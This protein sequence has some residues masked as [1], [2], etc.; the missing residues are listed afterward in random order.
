MKTL[1][2]RKVMPLVLTMALV[3]LM[4]P[5][6]AL[7]EDAYTYI[8]AD[9]TEKSTSGPVTIIAGTGAGE[10]LAS[11][12]YIVLA[13]GVTRSSTLTVNG[14]VHLI[15][16]D[17]ASLTVTGSSDSAGVK[18]IE[19]KSLTIYGQAG[20]TGMLTANGGELGAGI[21]SSSGYASGTVNIHGGTVHATGGGGIGGAG[22]GGAGIGGGYF[23]SGTVNISGGTVHA[24]GGSGISGAGGAGIGGGYFSSGTVNISGGTVHA[25]GGSGI[26]GAGGAGIGGGYF[27]SGTVNISGGTVHATGGSGISG[28]G[29][30]GIGGGYFSSG[31]VNISGGSV[32]AAGNG[33]GKDIG[34]GADS[35][36]HGTLKNGEGGANVYLTTVTLEG[37]NAV[38]P[39][40]SITTGAYAYGIRDM[41]TDADGKLYLYLPEGTETTAAQTETGDPPVTAAYTASGGPIITLNDHS[42]KGTLYTGAPPTA[43]AF[44]SATADGATGAVTSTRIDLAFS[45]AIAGLTANDITITDGT[46]SAIKGALTGSGTAWSIALS[47]VATEGTISVAV[48]APAGYTI[49]GS[50]RTATV[51][52]AASAPTAIAFTSATT[53]GAAGT[54]TS[55]RIDLAFSPAIAGLTANDITIT[56]GTG[57]AIK[58]ALTGSGTAWSIALSSVATEGTISVAVSAPAGYTITGSPQTATVYKAAVIDTHDL[59]VTA[60]DPPAGV[61]WTGNALTFTKSG[62]YTVEMHEGIELTTTDRIVVNAPGTVNLTLN[63][64]KIDL[65][66]IGGACVLDIQGSSAV[67]LT[68]IGANTLTSGINQAGIHVPAGATLTISG[69]GSLTANGGGG[70]GPGGA[71][72]GGSVGEAGG[73]VNISGGTGSAIKGALTGSGTAWSIALSSVATEGTISVAV[74]APAGYTITG[75]PRTATVYK[76]V[77]AV[78]PSI[79]TTALADATVGLAYTQSIECSYTGIGTLTFSATGLPSGLSIDTGTGVISGTPAAGTDAGFPYTVTVGVTDGTLSDSGTYSLTVNAA[80]VP[81]IHTITASAGSGGRISPS[82]A[83]SVTEGGSQTFTITANAGYAISS[84]MVDGV[85]VGAVSSHAFYSVAADHTIHATFRYMGPE[86]LSRALIDPATGIIVSGTIHED[87]QLTVKPLALHLEGACATCDAIRKAQKDKRMIFGGHRPEPGIYRSWPSPFR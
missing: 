66:G 65:A 8:D 4:L 9:G 14:S 49:T 80:P 35:S 68:L 6:S 40:A 71:G 63:G 36:D 60:A 51:Y 32:R 37:V 21:G 5:I 45:P 62:S 55:T 74:S 34:G 29:G 70:Y 59:K 85:N 81:S 78:P 53:D 12:W 75:S 72:I 15:L 57:S 69:A 22:G 33:G 64:V 77:V 61:G 1:L 58:G 76:A 84:V 73:A 38:T 47:S 39:V 50:P 46:G 7:A 86:Y 28:A 11:G 79:T 19:G 82:G 16:A 43:V 27:S 23:S 3:F 52:K 54:V 44:T 13:A 20:G 17:G 87:A 10:T 41:F 25:T 2:K 30:A 83:V 48:S 56:D 42:A 67:N 31:T 24:T 18:V 26:S